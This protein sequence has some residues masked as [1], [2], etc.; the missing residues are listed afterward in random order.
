MAKKK[1]KKVNKRKTKKLSLKHWFWALGI[2]CLLII[3]LP[4]TVILAVGMVPTFVAFLVD[5]HPGKNKTFTIGVMNFAG[6]FPYLLD[7]WLHTNSM[8]VALDNIMSPYSYVIMY[9]GAAAGYIINMVVSFLVSAML[10][11]KSDMRLKKIYV[12]KTALE[13]RWG[14]G[15]NTWREVQKPASDDA[16]AT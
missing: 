9:G 1:T 3:F 8:N 10:V 5:R 2:L 14:S 16:P 15:V 7:V 13:E 4:T 11:Q 6:C 12:E